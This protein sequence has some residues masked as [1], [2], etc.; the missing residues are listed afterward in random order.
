MNSLPCLPF[1]PDSP[2]AELSAGLE[3]DCR[4]ADATVAKQD[5]RPAPESEEDDLSEIACGDRL[6][7]T[8]TVAVEIGRLLNLLLA[9]ENMIFTVMQDHRFNPTERTF[10]RLRS[11]LGDQFQEQG[12]RLAHISRRTRA[13]GKRAHTGWADFM[14]HRPTR[15]PTAAVDGDVVRELIKLHEE[16]VAKLQAGITLSTEGFGDGETANVLADLVA[17]HEKDAFMLRALLW[18]DEAICA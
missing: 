2:P 1:L 10:A 6:A 16:I 14:A 12:A 8:N 18:E 3:T 13:L 4:I 5:W 7:M 11:S 17:E 15:E 9:Q